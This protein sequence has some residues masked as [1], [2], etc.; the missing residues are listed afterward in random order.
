MIRLLLFLILQLTYKLT[1]ADNVTSHMK[2]IKFMPAPANVGQCQPGMCFNGS[3]TFDFGVKPIIEQISWCEYKQ[4]V[5]SKYLGDILLEPELYCD[6]K[7]LRGIPEIT[8]CSPQKPNSSF[9]SMYLYPVNSSAFTTKPIQL[10]WR[11]KKHRKK[12][13]SS[14]DIIILIPGFG[15]QP[16]VRGS[17]WIIPSI[18]VWT[19]FRQ[20]PVI[21]VDFSK[22]L[23]QVF[24]SLANSRTI[25]Q[26]VGYSLVNWNITGRSIVAGFSLGGQIVAEVG[27]YTKKYGQLVK[28]CVALDP[29]GLTF[30]SGSPEIRL[31]PDDCALVQVIHAASQP[32]PT[33]VGLITQEFGTFHH[34]GHCDF[35]LN[36]GRTQ[37]NDCINP[38]LGAIMKDIPPK[39][40]EDSLSA[41]PGC[42]HFRATFV[43]IASAA[44]KCNYTG[45]ECTDC[46]S[47]RLTD[48]CHV[49]LNGRTMNLPPYND[50]KPSD[51]LDFYVHA[52]SNNYPYCPDN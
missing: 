15:E 7:T 38:T 16:M 42:P 29:S 4:K 8:C 5:K 36:C 34:S 10:D 44:N 43:Y 52:P 32:F 2:N 46:A 24:Q 26:A 11:K 48:G 13:P 51:N 19:Q 12:I 22:S 45:V 28:E 31:T 30:D 41:F 33:N 1:F 21:V 39:N 6:P 25:G 23:T 49:D 9:P 20:T 3:N 14:G 17:M 37:G 35:W 40:M 47:V 18:E 27:K 50:C